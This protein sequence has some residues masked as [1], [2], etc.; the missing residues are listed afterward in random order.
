MFLDWMTP[1]AHW[2]EFVMG[3]FT[4]LGITAV[5]FI[6]AF[7]LGVVLGVMRFLPRINFLR[8]LAYF[9]ATVY[10]ELIRNTPA[11]VQIYLIYFGLPEFGIKTKPIVAG[12]LALVI[13]NSAYI[14]E[15]VRGGLR[16]IAAGQHEAGQAIG[17]DSLQIFR[18]II[19]PQALRNIFPA[20]GNQVLMVV[21]GTALLSIIDVREL[22]DVALTINAYTFRTIEIFVTITVMYYV[23]TLSITK[24]LA[25]INKKF[26]PVRM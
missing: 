12:V 10:I 21:F 15:I 13:L 17:L 3:A 7:G 20:L 18:L 8:K 9:L 11:L 24:L 1:I 2:K 22:T 26:F 16:S 5:I 23:M 4:T 25:F 14:A 19:F 6:A